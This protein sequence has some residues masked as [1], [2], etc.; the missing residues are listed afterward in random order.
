MY[1]FLLILS[2]LSSEQLTCL[3]GDLLNPSSNEALCG[4]TKKWLCHD[5]ALRLCGPAERGVSQYDDEGQ[6]S[7]V[8]ALVEVIGSVIVHRDMS[9]QY[10]EGTQEILD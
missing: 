2:S 9:A 4:N 5:P 6:E 1:V 7:I 10:A 8:D 3:L